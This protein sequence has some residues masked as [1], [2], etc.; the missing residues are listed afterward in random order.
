MSLGGTVQS[1]TS[2]MQC[3]ASLQGLSAEEVKMCL[4]VEATAS[5]GDSNSLKTEFKH[6][7]EDK[8]KTES[9]ASF[10]SVFNDRWG[11]IV[12]CSL[13]YR[14][15]LTQYLYFCLSLFTLP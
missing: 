13:T 9:K 5:V 3:Q 12:C 14:F 6:C 15:S 4:D 8:S 10:S 11:I 2:I 1:V 7:Q